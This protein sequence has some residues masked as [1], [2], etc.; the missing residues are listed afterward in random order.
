MKEKEDLRNNFDL[1]VLYVEDKSVNQ[2]VFSIMLYNKGCK[3][4]LASN[5]KEAVEMAGKNDYD[6]IFMDLQM[7][8][9]DGLTAAKIISTE[10]DNPPPIVAVTAYYDI[11]EES[12]LKENG[13]NDIVS[14]PFNDEEIIDK[15]ITYGIKHV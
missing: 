2:K 10:H 11:I 7:P 14:K 3:V 12:R 8:V 9:M 5:G 6:I 13:I 1:D 15:L 4:D